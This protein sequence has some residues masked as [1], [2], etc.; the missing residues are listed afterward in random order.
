VQD[1]LLG[2]Q[3]GDFAAK[4]FAAQVLGDDPALGVDQEI[5][6]DAL[7]GIVFRREVVKAVE[8]ADLHPAHAVL[9]DGAEPFVV[10]VVQRY[11]VYF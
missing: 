7:H 4:V 5:R 9:A 3:F 11:A 2:E 1:G 8:V 6:R 10:V